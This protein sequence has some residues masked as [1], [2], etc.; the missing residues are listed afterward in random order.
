[1]LEG[2]GESS[3]LQVDAGR[4]VNRLAFSPDGER[5]AAVV[6]GVEIAIWQLGTGANGFVL[7]STGETITDIAF[8]ADGSLLASV[9]TGPKQAFGIWPPNSSARRCRPR[10]PPR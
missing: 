3:A 7:P 8:S 10:R 2:R 6:D 4:V 5:L 1:V 9:G